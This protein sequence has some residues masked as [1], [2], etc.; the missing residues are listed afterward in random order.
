[1]AT[2][3]RQAVP[4]CSQRSSWARGAV[5][6]WAARLSVRAVVSAGPALEDFDG[7]DDLEGIADRRAEGLVHGGEQVVHLHAH[8]AAD[9]EETGGELLGLGTRFHEGPSRISHRGR[10]DRAT[11]RASCS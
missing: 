1:M 7:L 10:G 9:G 5:E 6:T 2:N 3:F 4:S 11:P 8:F